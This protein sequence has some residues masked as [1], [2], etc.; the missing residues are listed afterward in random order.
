MNGTQKTRNV[1]GATRKKHK[2]EQ[3]EAND[4]SSEVVNDLEIAHKYACVSSCFS[5]LDLGK[6]ASSS[7]DFRVA[8]EENFSTSAINPKIVD[9]SSSSSEEG[10]EGPYSVGESIG[11]SDSSE[12]ESETEWT[13]ASAQMDPNEIIDDDEQTDGG[14]SRNRNDAKDTQHSKTNCVNKYYHHYLNQI[15]ASQLQLGQQQQV[16]F[17]PKKDDIIELVGNIKSHIIGE[18]VIVVES[19]S[20]GSRNKPLGEGNVLLLSKNDFVD[21]DI[22]D[23]PRDG[24]FPLGAICEVFGPVSR[25]LYTVQLPLPTCNTNPNDENNT[26]GLTIQQNVEKNTP[27][28]DHIFTPYSHDDSNEGL[29]VTKSLQE[30]EEDPWSENGLHTLKLNQRRQNNLISVYFERKRA[31][32]VDTHA[33]IAQSGRGCDVNEEDEKETVEFSD[34]EAERQYYASVKKR[35]QKPQQ[36][37]QSLHK[38]NNTNRNSGE[39]KPQF[40][41]NSSFN[42]N[43]DRHT[44][45]KNFHPNLHTG[46]LGILPFQH[47]RAT[48]FM[49]SFPDSNTISHPHPYTQYRHATNEMNPPRLIAHPKDLPN[50]STPNPSDVTPVTSAT[51]K[52]HE[53]DTVYYHY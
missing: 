28:E 17:L 3:D 44:I 47:Q 37:Q 26:T 34:D 8:E 43:Q 22:T 6:P 51:R 19:L 38:T 50:V 14:S 15:D 1:L 24:Y 12:Y 32:W 16:Q 11:S 31:V 25:P 33:V 53:A 40:M 5:A 27:H 46:T 10:E 49:A 52:D 18:R 39:T 4:L 23:T 35:T 7:G 29:S 13:E 36:K 20:Y 9:Y 21:E 2:D 48:T 45:R 30:I 42:T 41:H